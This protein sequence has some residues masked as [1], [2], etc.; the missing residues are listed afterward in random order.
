MGYSIEKVMG[1]VTV[2]AKLRGKSTDIKPATTIEGG[3][4]RL[5]SGATF[6]CW[7]TGTIFYY[8]PDQESTNPWV[9]KE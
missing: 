4:I 3:K 9:L 6:F 2:P 7:D 5:T 1:V 8:D